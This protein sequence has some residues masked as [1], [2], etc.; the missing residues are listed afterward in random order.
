MNFSDK[1]TMW[2]RKRVTCIPHRD[3]LTISVKFLYKIFE[4]KW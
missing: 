1:F 2:L 4:Y 3:S